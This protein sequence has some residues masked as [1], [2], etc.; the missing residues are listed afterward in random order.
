MTKGFSV[1]TLVLFGWLIG[2]LGG[3]TFY[4]ASAM[5]LLGAGA[6]WGSLVLRPAHSRDEAPAHA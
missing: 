5:M 3:Q 1:V 4:V 2:V 6:A